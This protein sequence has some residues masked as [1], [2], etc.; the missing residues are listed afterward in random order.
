[1]FYVVRHY[2]TEHGLHEPNRG[3][4]SSFL[5]DLKTAQRFE[6]KGEAVRLADNR[7]AET[8]YDYAVIMVETVSVTSTID[9]LL[10]G[11]RKRI[12][13]ARVVDVAQTATDNQR[14]VTQPQENIGEAAGA[15]RPVVYSEDVVDGIVTNTSG[16]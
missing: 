1:M 13:E 7:K 5:D 12:M 9:E 16:L 6:N 8:G 10:S 4:V 11:H 15:R 3:T 14:S 2:E